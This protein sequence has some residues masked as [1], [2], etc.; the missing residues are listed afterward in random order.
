MQDC[1]KSELRKYSSEPLNNLLALVMSGASFP[2][3]SQE[4]RS[5]CRLI[6]PRK[7]SLFATDVP[8]ASFL[9]TG[10]DLLDD[11]VRTVDESSLNLR[12]LLVEDSDQHSFRQ[13]I[14]RSGHTVGQGVYASTCVNALRCIAS[15][16]R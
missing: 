15:L 3:H 12:R 10:F 9:W 5:M 6:P 11:T 2:R 16:D 13:M 8:S 4:W 7:S 14:Q 1:M